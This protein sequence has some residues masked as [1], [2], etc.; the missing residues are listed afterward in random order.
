[1][2]AAGDLMAPKA[3]KPWPKVHLIY[4]LLAAFDLIAVGGGLYLS[5]RLI[6][7]LETNAAANAEWDSRFN[8][9]WTLVDTA[10]DANRAL[11]SAM[12]TGNID[13]AFGQFKTKAVE[14]RHELAAFNSYVDKGFPER[15]VKRASTLLAKMGGVMS[16][17]EKEAQKVVYQFRAGDKETAVRSMAAMQT[18]YGNLRFMVNDLNR[19]ISMVKTARAESSKAIVERL[20]FFEYVIGGMIVLMVGCVVA[21]GHWIGRIMKSK[22]RELETSNDELQEAQA[23]V[24]RLCRAAPDHQ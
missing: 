22:Y 8:S 11:I 9:S 12:D 15:L 2:S 24:S 17:M 5:H 1:M 23:E 21:Y 20:R 19:M 13:I 14:F 6:E 7:V 3:R 10:A 4:F 16:S 18:K